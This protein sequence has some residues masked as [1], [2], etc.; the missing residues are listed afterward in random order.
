MFFLYYCTWVITS[1]GSHRTEK[2]E[3]IVIVIVIA[4]MTR[5]D[6]E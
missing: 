5:N 2:K 1:Y 6:Q 4:R 3:L